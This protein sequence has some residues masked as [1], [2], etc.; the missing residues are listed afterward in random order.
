M[1]GGGS[2]RHV[3]TWPSGLGKGLQSPVPGF[4]SR[5]RLEEPG[6]AGAL[7]GVCEYTRIRET[8]CI[9]PVDPVI[10]VCDGLGLNHFDD[11]RVH[12]PDGR[13]TAVGSVGPGREITT[14]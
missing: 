8:P 4:D 1:S 13:R 11:T 3:A 5:R 12:V 10:R 9:N 7:R 6:G 14:R 2:N